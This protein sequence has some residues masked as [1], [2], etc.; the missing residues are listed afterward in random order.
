MSFTLRHAVNLFIVY[1]LTTWSRLLNT[2]F[3]LGD[4]LFGAVKLTK[5]SH[6]D[7]YGCMKI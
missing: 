6:K 7:K 3:P 1:E 5:N 2:V 4:C